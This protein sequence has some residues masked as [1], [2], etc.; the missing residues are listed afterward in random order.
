MHAYLYSLDLATKTHHL[1]KD[2]G[3]CNLD[4]WHYAKRGQGIWA[5]KKLNIP[6]RPLTAL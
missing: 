3:N 2:C 6:L 5:I 4:T 1:F